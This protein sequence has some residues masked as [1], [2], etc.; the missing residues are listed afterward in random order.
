MPYMLLYC[1]WFGVMH[2]Y[3]VCLALWYGVRNAALWLI[4]RP[5]RRAT[6]IT[7]RPDSN[8]QLPSMRR[9]A[10]C[11]VR[12]ELMQRSTFAVR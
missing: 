5:G 7:A 2:G 1:A 8:L 6:L 12:L 11:A 4:L 9:P 10:E 3:A